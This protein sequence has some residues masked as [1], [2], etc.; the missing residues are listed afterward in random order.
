[1][2]HRILRHLQT[3]IV[4]YIALIVAVAGSGSYALANLSQPPLSTVGVCVDRGTDVLHLQAHRRC[5]RGQTHLL[6][7]P[8]GLGSA[9]SAW[10]TVAAPGVIVVGQ[11]VSVQHTGP[12]TYEVKVTARG[13]RNANTQAP[14]VSINAGLTPGG[15]NEFPVA[16][17]DVH[18]SFFETFAIYTGVVAN[19]QFT[20]QDE[21]FNFEDSCA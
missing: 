2:H 16:W 4:G 11:G 14:V 9:V 8:G 18:S 19:G 13:C 21:P 10:A 7:A 1:V 12:G 6:L 17:T 3:N 5:G 20:A 15:I